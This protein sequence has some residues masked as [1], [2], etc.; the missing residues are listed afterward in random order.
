M[1]DIDVALQ[2]Y[3]GF[4]GFRGAQR[5]IIETLLSGRDL[6]AVMPTGGGKSLCYQLPAAI[7]EGTA[8]VV[9][10]LI[11]LMK[12]QV[13][14][15]NSRG[16]P[17]AY[18]NSSLTYEQIRD[19]LKA[20]YDGLIKLLYVAP[21]R[22]ESKRFMEALASLQV[23]FV[24]VD[25]AHCI[26]EWGHDF[27]PAYTNIASI[28]DY[29]TDVQ[30][31][32]FTATAT[33]EV[34]E[35]IISSLTLFEPA[36]Y[37]KG[38]SRSN[39]SLLTEVSE[40]KTARAVDFLKIIKNEDSRSGSAIVY[41]GSRK[42]VAEVTESI[43]DAGIK[44][45]PYHAGMTPIMREAV[46]NKFIS[47]KLPVIVATNAFGMGVDKSDVRVVIHMDMP[48]TLEA[49]YQEAGRA[50]RDGKNSTCLF[51]Y[52]P[53]DYSLPEFFIGMMHPRK[54]E[55]LKVFETLVMSELPLSINQCANAAGVIG[56]TA[57]SCIKVLDKA[58]IVSKSAGAG[59]KLRFNIPL[60]KVR[61]LRESYDEG[62]KELLDALIRGV[63]R[64]SFGEFADFNL[65]NLAS[66]HYVDATKLSGLIKSLA[67][68]G[69][70]NYHENDSDGGY[71]VKEE[72][73]KTKR[74]PLD[75]EKLENRRVS[76]YERLIRMADYLHTRECKQSYILDYF[77]EEP[78]KNCGNC[79]SCRQKVSRDSF[80]VN[81]NVLSLMQQLRARNGGMTEREIIHAL[82]TE[83]EGTNNNKSLQEKKLFKGLSDFKF[84][85]KEL[86]LHR[87]K[88]QNLI[89]LNLKTKKY[90]MTESGKINL[91][92][93]P[94]TQSNMK[95][96]EPNPVFNKLVALRREIAEHAGVV[97]RG[98]ISDIALKKIAEVMP[99]TEEDMKKITGISQLFVQKFSKLFL[100][101]ITKINTTR[102]EQKISKVAQETLKLIRQGQSLEQISKRLFSNSTMAANY[103]QEIV[104]AGYEVERER[105]VD[106]ST[107]KA[108]IE[109][110]KKNEQIPLRDMQAEIAGDIDLPTLRMAVAFAKRE[111]SESDT[112][113]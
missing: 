76:A 93:M 15:L 80:L 60:E 19:R 75:F 24:A 32:A 34:R 6:L 98:I 51:L 50:G 40:N 109:F 107:Y 49:Y 46:Q 81:K 62:K 74:L 67:V 99:K 7:S 69:F 45:E 57:E 91:K 5:E 41:C 14:A 1:I 28:R 16:I 56:K 77:G 112:I 90:F 8:I 72:F 87:L 26:S 86:I 44:A 94:E 25:E 85:E 84:K 53:R 59:C 42:R 106:D 37:I 43:R 92:K 73:L 13:D 78:E 48:M 4:S 52:E 63:P 47:G 38:F 36:V 29:I 27:R 22:L 104:D 70:V 18:I 55:I 102:K 9:S 82:N 21:E 105:F 3:F 30:I 71:Y 66:R 64:E 35:D 110:L 65:S 23:S 58:G 68:A 100:S 83:T 89:K 20:A 95:K 101:E 79:T 108:V 17:A 96:E 54:D 10:P 12:D 103:I 11:A 31:T 39:L 33:P 88:S 97:P 61:E 2:E 113:A 111:I